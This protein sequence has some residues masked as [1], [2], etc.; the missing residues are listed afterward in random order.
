VQRRPREEARKARND[1][2]RAHILEV[3]EQV[4]ADRGFD[5][6]KLQDISERAGL[7]MG[8]I[9]AI[10]PGKDELFRAILDDKGLELVRLVRGVSAADQEP[11]A[12]LHA[13][14]DA[15][16]DY[17]VSH[18]NFLRMHLRAGTSWIVSPE[19]QPAS[20][21]RIWQEVHALQAEIF[22]RGIAAGVFV[23]EDPA[24]LARLFSAMDQVLLADWVSAGMKASR[25]AL[26]ERLKTLVGRS[27][28]R[29]SPP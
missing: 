15:Y 28:V 8:T 3:A 4:F 12:Q 17:F 14:I 5:S 16:I 22:R 24:F 7:S 19:P 11:L 1:V 6:A 27:F 20:R 13:L 23:D 25:E 9:Y 18:P 21:A 2:Y 10:F 29:R 26:V